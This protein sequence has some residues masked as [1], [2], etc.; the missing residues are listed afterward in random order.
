VAALAPPATTTSS[1]SSS[2]GFGGGCCSTCGGSNALNII[3]WLLAAGARVDVAVDGSTP[4]HKAASSGCVEAVRLLLSGLGASTAVSAKT[5]T[6]ATPLHIAAT[7]G[8]AAII[9][10]ILGACGSAPSANVEGGDAIIAQRQQ[11]QQ[12]LFLRVSKQMLTETLNNAGQSPLHLAAAGNHVAA[13]KA[14]AAGGAELDSWGGPEGTPLHT[15]AAAGH[16]S[17]V[18][19]LLDAGADPDAAGSSATTGEC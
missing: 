8:S 3:R 5:S 7:H 2:N 9:Q 11:Q 14:L 4:L 10:A 13:I 18:Q 16:V 1:S 12:P 6:G 15:A 19:A 17:A